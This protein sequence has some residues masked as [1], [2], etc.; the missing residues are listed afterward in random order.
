MQSQTCLN[1]QPAPDI[2]RD[3][4]SKSNVYLVRD[5]PA[6]LRL[7]SMASDTLSSN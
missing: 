5:A 3:K 2:R 1:G 7:I 6:M 4:P